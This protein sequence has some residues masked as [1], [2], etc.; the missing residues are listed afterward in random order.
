[1]PVGM[2]VCVLT[3]AG[4]G[5]VAPIEVPGRLN[6]E[7]GKLFR[8]KLAD[9]PNRPGVERFPTVEIPRAGAATEP[10][11]T[12]SAIPVEFTDEDFDQVT[13]GKAVMKVVYLK[14]GTNGPKPGGRQGEPATIA[15]YDLEPGRDVIAEARRRGAIL[16]V[17]RVGNIDLEVDKPDRE[18]VKE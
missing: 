14:A 12:S 16:A 7:Q 1:G 18:A 2:T 13:D 17:V 3:A 4:Q 8:L 9:V 5:K 6:L 11:V 10:F 15:S